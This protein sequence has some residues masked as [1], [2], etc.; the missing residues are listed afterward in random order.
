MDTSMDKKNAVIMNAYIA[1]VLALLPDAV[2][3][4]KIRVERLIC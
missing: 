2:F 4:F 1:V 3:I